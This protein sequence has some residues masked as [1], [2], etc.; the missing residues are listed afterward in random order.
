MI[1]L[2]SASLSAQVLP[3]GATLAGLWYNGHPHSLVIGSTDADAYA[4]KL[5]YFGALIGPIANRI[6]GATLCIDGATCKMEPN[7]GSSCLHSG[8]DGLHARDW[9]VVR[10][11]PSAVSLRCFLR[12]GANGLPGNRTVNVDYSL[13]DAGHLILEMTASSDRTTAINLAH[14]PYWNLGNCETVKDHRLTIYA[15]KYL[16]V[17]AHTL[18]TGEISPVSGT[19][20][21]FQTGR[22]VPT[23]Q[24][25]DANLCLAETRRDHPTPAARLSGP[26]GLMLQIDT[27][28]PGLQV[29]NGS[30]LND[31]KNSLHDQRVLQP[32]S[33]I[34]LEPQAWPDAPR[35][36][37]FPS[38]I[39]RVGET[40]RQK[41]TYRIWDELNQIATV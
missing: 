10:Q 21:D 14:H 25:L 3:F 32:F 13:T 39:L 12:D 35:H 29:Y 22:L 33:G 41:T 31:I 15:D 9:T 30:G 1:T 6:S 28:E 26:S 34:A 24:T 19:A 18:P 11:S 38:I 2:R 4:E 7:E 27:T 40:Y 17:D 37:A 23:D 5:R 16:P 8:A 20:Y 36:S